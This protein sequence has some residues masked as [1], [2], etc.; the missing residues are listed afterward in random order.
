MGCRMSVKLQLLCSHLDFF[1]KNLGDFSEKHDER[2]R[3][4]IEP[5][6]K[7]YKG[8][9]DSAMMGDYIWSLVRQDKSSHKRKAR[10]TVHY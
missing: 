4:V 9:W 8:S 7:R 3:Q 6:E 10:S 5:M 1:Q 2:F